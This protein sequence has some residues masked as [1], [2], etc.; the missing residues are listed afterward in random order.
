MSGL[1]PLASLKQ[2]LS[3]NVE[4]LIDPSDAAFQER[5]QRWS[6]IGKQTPAAIVLPT[7][8]EEIQKIVMLSPRSVEKCLVLD[9]LTPD[10]GAMG[11]PYL[12]A[13]R[14]EEWWA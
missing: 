8:E 5:L 12:N 3:P 14:D 4:M 6:D 9:D 10:S 13:V 11:C 2:N 1:P 7:S